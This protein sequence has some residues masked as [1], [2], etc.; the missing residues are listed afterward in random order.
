MRNRP[1]FPAIAV[2]CGL[3]LATPP[4]SAQGRDISLI[5]DTEIENTI[6]VY[7]S[8]IFEAAGLDA[9]AVD[10]HLVRDDAL[11]AFVAGGQRMFI[12]TGL[13]MEA[14]HAGQVIGV[15]A[16]EAGHIT[17]GHLARLHEGIGDAQNTALA[18][19]LLGIPAAIL[20]GRGD[21]AAAA[22]T[23]GQH[24]GTR[25]FLQYTR[26][27]EQAAD[28]AAVRYLDRAQISSRGMLE[29]MEKLQRQERLY[30]SNPDPYTRTH[31]LT[32]S[33]MSFVRNHLET[34]PAT[35]IEL[36]PTY[37]R[38]HERMQAKLI[39]FIRPYD[40]TLRRYPHSDTSVPARY[41]RAIAL[42][43]RHETDASV[44]AI[45]A[46]IA[47]YPDDPFFR[48]LKGQ[49]LREGGRLEEALE[50]YRTAA[51]MLP[52]AALI[53]WNLSRVLIELNDP[54]LDDE[55]E[56]HLAQAL[57]YEPKMPGIWRLLATV[58]SRRGDEG[59][60]ALAQAEFAINRGERPAAL[61][62]ARRALDMLPRGSPGWLR[63]Q[64]IE[65]QAGRDRD[66][67]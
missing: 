57:R 1:L 25:Q 65:V 23:L 67:S 18:A 49:I 66:G 56:Q 39:G 47:D 43:Q 8:R 3:F 55:A 9:A 15:L 34:S 24:V 44:E 51:E 5:R 11:N 7:T 38:L 27:M 17:G 29:F 40:Q 45:D 41:A 62:H 4:A 16:H 54:E 63:A 2:L 6:R 35:D 33:R 31:P 53:R 46:L 50:P 37:N 58:Y 32:E 14:D 42:M 28:Q 22:T 19:M 60:T 64:D 20:T 26:G 21:V 61:A 36:D 10:V 52:W 13:L 30:T 59:N 48:E 12:H